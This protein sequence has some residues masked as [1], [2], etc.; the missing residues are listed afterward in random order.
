MM[1]A[2]DVIRIGVVDNDELALGALRSVIA[3]SDAWF[4]VIWTCALGSVAVRRCLSSATRPQVLV[5]DMAMEEMSGVELCAKIRRLNAGIGIVGV[6]SYALGPYRRDLAAAGAQALVSKTD[7]RGLCEAIRSAAEGRGVG[8]GCRSSAYD[9]MAF[10]DVE[11]AERD[12][13]RAMNA[14]ADSTRAPREGG[15]FFSAK[16][17]ASELRAL[18]LYASGA[19]TADIA[20]LMGVKESTVRT[21]EKRGIA[22]LGARSR[23]HAI[24]LCLTRHLW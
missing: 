9:A 5:V 18:R 24:A 15:L 2:S 20:A 14:H 8:A 17:S 12:V 16:L 11:D 21:F 3:S 1:S 4:R 22:K 7:F 6:T 23:A 19:S 13:E 10:P